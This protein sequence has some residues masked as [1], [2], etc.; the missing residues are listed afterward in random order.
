MKII[1][2]LQNNPIVFLILFIS[3]LLSI[4]AFL[5]MWLPDDDQRLLKDKY[6]FSLKDFNIGTTNNYK[7]NIGYPFLYGLWEI[8]LTIETTTYNAYKNMR[9]K[10]EVNIIQDGLNV[11]A[12]GH[13]TGEI[14]R[15]QIRYHTGAS[16]TPINLSGYLKRN[17]KQKYTL[18]LYGTEHGLI[19][20]IFKT[21]FSLTIIDSTLLK[22][23]FKTDGAN[24]S[25]Y[26]TWRRINTK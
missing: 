4:F 3:A 11:K 15:G 5:I 1:E 18:D 7:S 16:Q 9:I 24:S 17:K 26:A 10:Y 2:K 14:F 12:D 23:T 22:G 13:K 19:K 8:E 20:G 25:G 21:E 6:G